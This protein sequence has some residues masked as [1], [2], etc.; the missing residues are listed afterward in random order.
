MLG[1]S[2][3]NFWLVLAVYLL[4]YLPCQFAF[5]LNLCLSKSET[6]ILLFVFIACL[7]VLYQLIR[8]L[9]A[10][11]GLDMTQKNVT[12]LGGYSRWM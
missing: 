3:S 4:A 5:N 2:S 8:N 10:V 1:C 11:E 9:L 6:K 12:E 7:L